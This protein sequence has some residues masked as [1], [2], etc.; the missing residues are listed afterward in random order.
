M[1]AGHIHVETPL[2]PVW[3]VPP[4]WHTKLDEHCIVDVVWQLVPEYPAGQE[5]IGWPN[6]FK[7]Q[8]P[9]FWQGLFEHCEAKL[10]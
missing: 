7:L 1:F 6:E 4:F 9:P 5:H 2:V 3:H 8:V 10:I